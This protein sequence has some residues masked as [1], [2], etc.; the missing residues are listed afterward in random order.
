MAAQVIL[1]MPKSYSSGTAS[2]IL[3]KGYAKRQTVS[4][5][6]V[7]DFYFLITFAPHPETCGA[8]FKNKSISLHKKSTA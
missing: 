4:Y 8:F 3:R 5:N 1:L 7:S 6:Q 2:T